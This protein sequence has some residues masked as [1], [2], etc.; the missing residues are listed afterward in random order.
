MPIGVALGDV[1][2]EIAG[3]DQA[4][5]WKFCARKLRHFIGRWDE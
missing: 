5:L 3:L 1:P 2:D 4:A